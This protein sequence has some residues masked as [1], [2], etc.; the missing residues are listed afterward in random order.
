[1]STHVPSGSL[2][3]T[4]YLDNAATTPLR[5][6]VLSAMLPYFQE[7]YGNP[8]SIHHKGRE[9]K[10]A[11]E[12]AREEVARAVGARPHEIIFTSG[13]TEANNLALRGVAENE[14]HRKSL[15]RVPKLHILVSAIEHV[16][17]LTTA[18]TL[19]AE[20]FEVEY[21][22]VD[23]NGV[24]SVDAV[25]SRAR[26]DT[27][28][29]SIMYANNEIGT[30]EPIAEIARTL[31]NRFGENR[32]LLHTDACQAVGQLPV[33]V[34]ELGVDLMTINSG[35]IY[36][37]K[38][39]GLLYVR[40]GVQ[41]APQIT[42][43]EQ[44]H[45]TRAG[46]E[47]VAGIVGFAK[48]LTCAVAEMETSSERLS[49][50]RDA[51]IASIQNAIPEVVVNGHPTLRLP[52]NIHF[53]FP[54]IEGESLVLLL[55]MHGICASTGSA[56]NAHDLL[57]SHVLRAIRQSDD[58]M[59]GSIRFSLGMHTTKEDLEFTVSTLTAC[60]LRLKALSPLPL[61]L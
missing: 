55:D 27:A 22:P 52:N 13:G 11:L 59:H 29:I 50:L 1:M 5:E 41:F 7:A 37:P 14:R 20:G 6:E 16:S 54:Y 60:A 8:S 2:V 57:P 40:E 48:A 43:G 36:G 3:K 24:V 18:E 17:V 12:G 47:N 38:G 49:G 42:G 56:C 25:L 61:N 34:T 39:V 26:V 28:L 9:A 15:I 58:L 53:S 4:I 10:G 31:K 45:H 30:I 46:T 19:K 51:F 32:P 35:K 23:T 33:N 44:E 21:I